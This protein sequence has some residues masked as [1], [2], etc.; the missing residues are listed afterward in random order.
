MLIL[1]TLSKLWLKKHLYDEGESEIVL[2]ALRG[3]DE[4]QEVKACN[5][6]NANDLVDITEEELAKAGLVAGYMG[7]TVVPE[8]VKVV[9]DNRFKRCLFDD[10][11]SQ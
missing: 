1:I 2:F 6:V 9:F 10:M 8:G 7:P 5:A 11:W 3:S 4:L